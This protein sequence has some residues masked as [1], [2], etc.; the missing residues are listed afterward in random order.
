MPEKTVRVTLSWP[1]RIW[2]LI[3]GRFTITLDLP[4]GDYELSGDPKGE[5]LIEEVNSESA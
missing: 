1:M 4:V 3:R 2:V 5:F